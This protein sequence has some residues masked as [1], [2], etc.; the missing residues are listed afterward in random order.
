MKVNYDASVDAFQLRL[1]P[2]TPV[3]KTIEWGPGV[4]V[5]VDAAGRLLGVEVLDASTH[6]EKESLAALRPPSNPLSLAQAAKESGLS[7]GTL[8]VLLNNE[9]L[10]GSKRGR[11][12]IVE[13]AD[14]YTYLESRSPAGRPALTRKARRAPRTMMGAESP[15]DLLANADDRDNHP[16]DSA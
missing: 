14:L 4:H 11:D 3:A 9:R 2:G 16:P 5:D 8:R 13:K 1:A 6:F 7:A 10:K 15:E 12:W